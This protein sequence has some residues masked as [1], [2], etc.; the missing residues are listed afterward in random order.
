MKTMLVLA[1]LGIS[2]FVGTAGANAGDR[3]RG[4]RHEPRVHV[5]H[6]APAPRFERCWIAP[7]YERICV[8]IDA[9][10]VPLFRVQ[11]VQGGYWGTRT[12]D[13]D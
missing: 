7:R 2:G 10:G 9:C 1:T 8:G 4:A 13:C 5:R 6:C 11:C 12:I 3:D